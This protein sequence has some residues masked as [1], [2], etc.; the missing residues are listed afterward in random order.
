MSTDGTWWESKHRNRLALRNLRILLAEDDLLLS[1]MLS[2]FLTTFYHA[3]VIAVTSA[4]EVLEVIQSQ[5]PDILL[6]NIVLP[7]EDGYTL[8]QKI[9]T[10]TPEQG[11]EIPAIAI[12][13]AS[14]K[15]R[16][17]ILEAG[18]QAYFSK[19]FKIRQV[20]EMIVVLTSSGSK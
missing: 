5:K 15:N 14:A 6:S 11:G 12:T 18:F 13:G 17:R 1:E 10:L 4:A 3:E 8:I 19:P 2:D 16:E 20:I 7:D 9:R